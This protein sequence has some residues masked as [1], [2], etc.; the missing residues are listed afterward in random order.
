MKA[1]TSKPFAGHRPRGVPVSRGYE[2]S[3]VER[4]EHRTLFS[5]SVGS[6]DESFGALG[7][8]YAPVGGTGLTAGGAH[9][10]IGAD[11]DIYVSGPAGV[12]RFSQAGVLDGAYGTAGV[13]A[14]PSGEFSSVAV[15]SLG[16]LYGLYETT[17]GTSQISGLNLV[18]YTS[19]GVIDSSFGT[20]GVVRLDASGDELFSAAQL[21]VQPDGKVVVAYADLQ[22]LTVQ[23]FDPDGSRDATFADDGELKLQNYLNQPSSAN[24]EGLDSGAEVAGCSVMANGDILVGGGFSESSGN[25]HAQGGFYAV[26]LTPDG[27]LDPTY[28]SGGISNTGLEIGSVSYAADLR[29]GLFSVAAGEM[30]MIV[31]PYTDTEGGDVLFNASGQAMGLGA[32][33]AGGELGA[34]LL[35]NGQ[36]VFLNN[37]S[38]TLVSSAGVEGT[39]MT[40]AAFNYTPIYAV[41]E[42]QPIAIAPDGDLLAI[43]ASESGTGSEMTA[44]S[45]GTTPA[46]TPEEIPDATTNAIA[47]APDGAIDLAFHNTSSN[48]LQFVTQSPGGSWSNP[49]TIDSSAG[50]GGAISIATGPASSSLIDAAYYDQGAQS[51]KLATSS[52]GGV[53]FSTQTIDAN[54]NVGESPSIYVNHLGLA[55]VAFFNQTTQHLQLA[56]QKRNGQWKISTIDASGNVGVDVVLVPEPSGRLTVA[57]SDNTRGWLRWGEQNANGTWQLFKATNAASGVAGISMTYG[58]ASAAAISFYDVARHELRLTNLTIGSG[59]TFSTQ[60]VAPIMGGTT[61]VLLGADAGDDAVV[62][63]DDA[64]ANQ[65]LQFS[66][67]GNFTPG[68]FYGSVPVADSSSFVSTCND[69]GVEIA[70][71]FDSAT[72]DLVVNAIG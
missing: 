51:L 57:Y 66:P 62:Y 35:T 14:A 48:D 68:E 34:A 61:S 3:A 16:D 18:R 29:P 9:V 63:A 47:A 53:T 23:R 22:A 10:I 2:C 64:S 50:A 30:A 42:T 71:Y 60:T 54:G 4:L 65:F 69:N 13:A 27:A 21:A 44:I 28:G 31:I 20:D 40:V 55:S 41:G 67:Y 7:H 43:G 26:R 1:R 8:A 12:A 17:T 58:S 11:G 70:A 46:P 59:D 5:S 56:R 37:N 39:P 45:L 15:D 24:N 19:T 25:Q 6:I 32:I 38:L 49:I 52:D 36:R 72:G 33:P